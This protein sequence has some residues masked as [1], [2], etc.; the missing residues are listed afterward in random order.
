MEQVEGEQNA[1]CEQVEGQKAALEELEM[2][3]IEKIPS[4]RS[5]EA[6]Q[7]RIRAKGEK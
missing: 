4:H 1:A 3:K 6:L 2:T 7:H 5:A